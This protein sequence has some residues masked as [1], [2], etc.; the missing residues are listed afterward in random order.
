[1]K[2]FDFGLAKELLNEER[3]EE[4]LYHMTGFTGAIRYMA[5]EIGL[6]QPYGLKADVYSWSMIMW[7]T[8]ALEPPMGMYTPNMFI[9]RVFKRGSRPILKDKW[10]E[11]LKALMKKCWSTDIR[12]PHSE[13]SWWIRDME[14]WIRIH[15]H[16]DS[17]IMDGLRICLCLFDSKSCQLAGNRSACYC[18]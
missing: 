11:G 18:C 4:G 12:A 5:P 16:G 6:R 3:A 17:P 1:L 7:Y 8:M 14:L 13:V 10:A 9:D 15:L 2:I